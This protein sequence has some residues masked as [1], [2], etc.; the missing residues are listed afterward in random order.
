MNDLNI[1]SIKP[2]KWNNIPICITEGFKAVVNENLRLDELSND[3]KLN[4][5][6]HR[7]SSEMKFKKIYADLKKNSEDS[8][9]LFVK[10]SKNMDL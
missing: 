8:T 1:G 5:E 9:N 4:I 7:K 6:E 10:N 2:E 3:L